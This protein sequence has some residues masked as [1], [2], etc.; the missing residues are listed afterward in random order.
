MDNR[1]EQRFEALWDNLWGIQDRVRRLESE[2]VPALADAKAQWKAFLAECGKAGLDKL[3]HPPR[4]ED[5]RIAADGEPGLCETCKE[6]H[7][8][9]EKC[10]SLWQTPLDELTQTCGPAD[11]RD[12]LVHW[13]RVHMVPAIHCPTAAGQPPAISPLGPCPICGASRDVRADTAPTPPPTT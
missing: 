8:T 1:S 9:D 12:E 10:E 11:W 7:Y 2:V 6:A 5:Y 4:G 13:C 3:E